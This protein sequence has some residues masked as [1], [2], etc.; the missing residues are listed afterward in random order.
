MARIRTM[1]RAVH[2]QKVFHNRFLNLF[3]WKKSVQEITDADKKQLLRERNL[4]VRRGGGGGGGG[5]G[6]GGIS[7]VL[8]FVLFVLFFLFVVVAMFS[9]LLLLLLFC[10]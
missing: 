3:A 10:C 5:G 1:Q 8:S 2:R 9:L 4:S 7:A 6:R